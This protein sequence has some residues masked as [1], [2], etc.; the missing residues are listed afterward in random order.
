MSHTPG[1]WK[2]D[3]N[4]LTATWES[5]E[6]VQLACMSRTQWSNP[7]SGRNRRLRDENEANA[8]LIAAAPELLESLKVMADALNVARLVMK[9]Q[10]TRD[11]AKALV[12]DARAVIAKAQAKGK[13]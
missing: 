6:R 3:G 2:L 10:D 7:D 11:L 12:A 8:S 9:E 5:G 13:P 4:S 1:P